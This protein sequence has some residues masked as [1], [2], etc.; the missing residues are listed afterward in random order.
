MRG[1]ASR[2]TRLLSRPN[3]TP[4]SGGEAARGES[5]REYVAP[6]CVT[7]PI[8]RC[9]LYAAS[10]RYASSSSLAFAAV[11]RAAGRDLGAMRRVAARAP[12]AGAPLCARPL[13][14]RAAQG[15][16]GQRC[17]GLDD[18]SAWSCE[19]RLV[20]RGQHL[21]RV[22]RG[23]LR[24]GFIDRADD[25]ARH[26]RARRDVTALTARVQAWRR[27]SACRPRL[28]KPSAGLVEGRRLVRGL[29][30][31]LGRLVWPGQRR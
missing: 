28:P 22:W 18:R 13:S 19:L 17:L 3:I 21:W 29:G 10:A 31:R 5:G 6:P 25:R 7:S 2:F 30:G 20:H 4:S 23:L 24:G 26:R 15:E 16:H 12:G 27:W 1:Q 11:L 8:P 9:V 14:T